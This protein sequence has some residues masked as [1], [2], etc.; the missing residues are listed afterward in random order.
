MVKL[1]VIM[2]WS[3]VVL[4]YNAAN[5]W[6]FFRFSKIF[7]AKFRGNAKKSGAKQVKLEI[8]CIKVL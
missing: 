2:W 4:I 1:V 7:A 8:R 6:R 5:V 3:S